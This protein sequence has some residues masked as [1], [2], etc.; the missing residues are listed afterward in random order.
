VF[1]LFD[2]LDPARGFRLW[3]SFSFA[4]YLLTV[5]LLARRYGAGP[6]GLLA[7]WALAL[8]GFWDTLAL[9]QIYVPL[10]LAAAASW[11]LLERGRTIPAGILMGIV[12]A[13]KPNFAVWPA[14]LMAAGHFRAPLAAAA[15]AV[16]L[17][18][19]PLAAYGS[20]VYYQWIELIL[21]DKDRAAFLTNVSLPGLAQRMGVGLLGTVLSIGLLAVLGAWAFRRKPSMLQA[22]ALGILGGIL[23]SPIAWIHYTLFLVPLFFTSRMSAPLLAAGLLLV[24]PVPVALRVLEAPAWVQVTIGSAYNWAVL[25]CLVA[26]TLELRKAVP[27]RSG[28]SPS[29]LAGGLSPSVPR[30]GLSASAQ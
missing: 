12:I 2:R 4:C 15:A 29:A 21:T 24:I 20:A 1:E 16:I 5:A 17:T 18:L 23:A 26:K 10:V 11:L 22:S 3:W 8:A 9:G 14:L 28:V 19:L 30:S 27:L 25:L 13:V 7:I 6:S